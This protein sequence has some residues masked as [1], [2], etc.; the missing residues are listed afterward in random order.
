MS[1][2]VVIGVAVVVGTF[3]LFASMIDRQKHIHL[4][5]FLLIIAFPFLFLIPASLVLE[6]TNCDLVLTNT[7]EYYR[8][9]DNFTNS[10]GDPTYH[11]DYGEPPIFNPSQDT[12]YIFHRYKRFTYDEQCYTTSNG[13]T[14]LF[15]GFAIVLGIFVIYIFLMFAGDI[16]KALRDVVKK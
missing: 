12:A 7:S 5:N 1:L 14:A 3:L 11:W 16:L 9:G 8:Y 6:Q 13:S 2:A 4:R 15:K 10:T